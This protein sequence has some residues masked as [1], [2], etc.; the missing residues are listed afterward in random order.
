MHMERQLDRTELSELLS[1]QHNINGR[2]CQAQVK[3]CC[4]C[5]KYIEWR[6]Q[7]IFVC[8]KHTHGISLFQC[9]G[10]CV[11]SAG[12]L[13]HWAKCIFSSLCRSF[14][15]TNYLSVTLAE[16]IPLPS[17]PLSLVPSPGTLFL[18]I[19]PS[20]LRFPMIYV[21]PRERKCG[22]TRECPL[23]LSQLH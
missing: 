19:T 7:Y 2:S 23:L 8:T 12:R 9:V 13:V 16:S 20:L 15:M 3:N 17:P 11:I 18:L 22:T 4:M 5:I 6:E 14:K 1:V 21:S 10:V